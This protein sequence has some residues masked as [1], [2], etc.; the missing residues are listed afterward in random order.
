MEEWL[1]E[2]GHDRGYA[3]SAQAVFEMSREW[4]RGRVDEDWVPPTIEEAEAIFARH[5]LTGDFWKM[6]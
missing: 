1:V 5:G 3:A 4:Y 6:G 2:T